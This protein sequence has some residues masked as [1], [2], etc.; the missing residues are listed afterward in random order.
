MRYFK[1]DSLIMCLQF[2]SLQDTAPFADSLGDL[3]FFGYINE[4]KD[5]PT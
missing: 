1:A 2:S 4:V 5:L 3:I